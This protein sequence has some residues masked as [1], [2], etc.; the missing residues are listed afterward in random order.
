MNI[1]VPA[2]LISALF[3]V[4][5][6]SSNKPS[7]QPSTVTL[8]IVADE[9]MNPNVH[10]ESSPV[11]LQVFELV[12]DSMFMSADFDQINDDFKKVLKSNYIKVYDYA[13]MPGQFKFVEEMKVDDDTKYI[14][15]L[16][17]YSEPELSEWKKAVKIVN[18]GR[19][20][21]VLVLLKDYDVILQ[22]VE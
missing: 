8:S 7:E 21:H 22:R 2:L 16:A 14:A 3:L 4:A 5:C 20:Y 18:V 1:R 15:V 19:Q 11:E 13:M 17:K 12:D 10:G 6:S 9:S